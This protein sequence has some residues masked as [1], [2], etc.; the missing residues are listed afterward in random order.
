M[1][2]AAGKVLWLVMMYLPYFFPS[3]PFLSTPLTPFS[4]LS[5]ALPPSSI[6][7]SY[8]LPLL[9]CPL[10]PPLPSLEHRPTRL[11]FEADRSVLPPV[12]ACTSSLSTPSLHSFSLILSHHSC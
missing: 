7:P 8:N 6:L 5:R 10:P 1:V 11:S 9:S 12:H 4:F 2:G 3:S